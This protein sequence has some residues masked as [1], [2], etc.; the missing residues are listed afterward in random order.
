[1]FE[2]V[3]GWRLVVVARQ[4]TGCCARLDEHKVRNERCL[5]FGYQG[6]PQTDSAITKKKGNK[7][8]F[9]F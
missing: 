8:S 6:Y 9:L 7:L 1:M 2:S 4:L 5:S 3:D